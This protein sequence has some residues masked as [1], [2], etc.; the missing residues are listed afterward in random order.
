MKQPYRLKWAEYFAA[1][2]IRYAFFSAAL[3]KEAAERAGGDESSEESGGEQTLPERKNSK[4]PNVI[5][6]EDGVSSNGE[7]ASESDNGH[8]DMHDAA[9]VIEDDEDLYVTTDDESL[10]E[11]EKG[12]ISK[13]MQQQRHY[14]PGYI[15]TASELLDLF[16]D[17]CPEPLRSGSEPPCLGCFHQCIVLCNVKT[18]TIRR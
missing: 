1:N 9:E 10:Q 16:V 13:T 7:D 12:S 3:A 8:F 11:G 17:E 2:H 18:C 4:N 6:G 15:L 14:P 5:P